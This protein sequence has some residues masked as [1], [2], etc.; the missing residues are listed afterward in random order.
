MPIRKDDEVLIV[1][2]THKGKEGK[3]TQVRVARPGDCSMQRRCHSSAS[4][5]RNNATTFSTGLP[6]EMGHPH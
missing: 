4:N 2:G 1:R 3:V 5:N 6:K